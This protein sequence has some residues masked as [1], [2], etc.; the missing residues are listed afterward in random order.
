[1][2]KVTECDVC[3]ANDWTQPYKV[4]WDRSDDPLNGHCALNEPLQYDICSLRCLIEFGKER[5]GIA[6]PEEFAEG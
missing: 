5:I 4:L 2:S 1:M 3:C 6:H